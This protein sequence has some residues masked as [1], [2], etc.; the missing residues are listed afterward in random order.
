MTELAAG[1][2][3]LVPWLLIYM[4]AKMKMHLPDTVWF[5][6][7]IYIGFAWS[8]Y[9]FLEQMFTAGLYLWHLSWERECLKAKAENRPLPKMSEV[10]RPTL[11]DDTSDLL[12]VGRKN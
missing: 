12:V 10:R 8:F 3:F 11:L 2:L 4:S 7:I 5:I 6:T 9:F 1:V